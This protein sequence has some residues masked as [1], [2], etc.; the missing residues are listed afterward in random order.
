VGVRSEAGLSK[1]AGA[2]LAQCVAAG[3]EAAP[4]ASPAMKPPSARS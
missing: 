4:Q 3:Q 2:F 1:A